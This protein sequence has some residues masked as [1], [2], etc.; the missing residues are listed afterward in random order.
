MPQAIYFLKF[1]PL[2]AASL[3]QLVSGRLEE[4]ECKGQRKWHPERTSGRLNGLYCKGIA[5]SHSLLS[6]ERLS[7]CVPVSEQRRIK[8]EAVDICLF[9]EAQQGPDLSTLLFGTQRHPEP[10]K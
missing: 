1:D 8:E 7:H 9:T 6:P 2:V 4:S 3:Y 10:P 5:K